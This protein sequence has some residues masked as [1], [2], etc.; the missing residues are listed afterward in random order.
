[1]LATVHASSASDVII[2]N[3][4]ATWLSML[5]YLYLHISGFCPHRRFLL[6]SITGGSRCYRTYTFTSQVF[7]LT[8]FFTE[9]AYW[10]LVMDEKQRRQDERRRRRRRR[11]WR[12]RRTNGRG[13][14]MYSA[15]R[16]RDGAAAK[17]YRT[18]T[19]AT[20]HQPLSTPL[21]TWGRSRPGADSPTG[22]AP[23]RRL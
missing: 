12:R 23:S 17:D 7:A 22:G 10:R 13:Q 4:C 19:H 8:G 5:S 20:K 1:M 16:R 2:C 3:F 11:R 6:R 9:I 21:S 15:P 14:N 18:R